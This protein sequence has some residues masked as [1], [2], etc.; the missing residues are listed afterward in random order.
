M[1]S[2][3][4]IP[5]WLTGFWWLPYVDGPLPIGE[6][7]FVVGGV[8][9]YIAASS[10]ENSIE[11]TYDETD[12]AFGTP[13]QNNN[14]DDDDDDDYYDDDNNFGGPQ[15]VGKTKGN[16][17]KS[18]KQQNKDFEYAAN[19][20][21]VP[22]KNRRAFHDYVTG[23]GFGKDELIEIAKTFVSFLFGV[24]GLEEEDV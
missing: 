11:I 6:I 22:L 12:V 13:P 5:G 15:K 8:L 9:I 10:Q 20:A 18:N 17:P 21:G 14:N 19:E 24:F 3:A 16:A 7:I 23:Q 1:N 2:A 4:A